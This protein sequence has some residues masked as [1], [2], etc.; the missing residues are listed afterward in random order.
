MTSAARTR[1]G[2]AQQPVIGPGHSFLRPKSW[3]IIALENQKK[4]TLEISIGDSGVG[5]MT[6]V[7]VSDRPMTMQGAIK[8]HPLNGHAKSSVWVKAAELVF[9]GCL[10]CCPQLF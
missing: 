7:K 10:A 4:A 3:G 1:Q 6:E 2:T 5:A 8:N 9:F